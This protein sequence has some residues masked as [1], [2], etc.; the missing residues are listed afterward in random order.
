MVNSHCS[1]CGV[2]ARDVLAISGQPLALCHKVYGKWNCPHR[3]RDYMRPHCADGCVSALREGWGMTY[4]GL[5]ERRRAAEM[6]AE[7]GVEIATAKV[8]GAVVATAPDADS[9]FWGPCWS[10]GNW[11]GVSGINA[12]YGGRSCID[13]AACAERTPADYS[14]ILGEEGYQ[15]DG[16]VVGNLRSQWHKRRDRTQCALFQR[17]ELVGQIATCKCEFKPLDAQPRKSVN[18]A[19]SKFEPW[20]KHL[21]ISDDEARQRLADYLAL[22]DAAAA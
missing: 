19:L 15:P 6:A 16:S 3:D 22:S 8:G 2:R 4:E 20:R 7:F 12:R 10:C 11:D 18:R 14:D 21:D 9:A 13:R 5:V 1:C 17:H